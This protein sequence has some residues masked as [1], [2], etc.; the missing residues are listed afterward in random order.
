MDVYS[1]YLGHPSKEMRTI[2][3]VLILLMKTSNPTLIL[4]ARRLVSTCL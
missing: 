1:D 3:Q 2:T 4:L